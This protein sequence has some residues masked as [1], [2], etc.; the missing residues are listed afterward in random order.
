[1]AAQKPTVIFSRAFSTLR[2]T[3]WFDQFICEFDS[4]F[5]RAEQNAAFTRIHGMG[6]QDWDAALSLHLHGDLQ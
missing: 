3:S 5:D 6:R 4:V 2:D 1:M